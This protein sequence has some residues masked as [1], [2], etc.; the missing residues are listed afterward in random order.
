MGHEYS[1]GA[2]INLVATWELP[3]FLAVVDCE[4]LH[5]PIGFPQS[6]FNHSGDDPAGVCNLESIQTNPLYPVVHLCGTG[7]CLLCFYRHL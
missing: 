7:H 3:I 2:A 6:L 5:S 1:E 4:F